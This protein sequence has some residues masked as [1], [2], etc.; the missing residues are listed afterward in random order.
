LVTGAGGFIGREVLRALASDQGAQVIA[1]DTGFKGMVPTPR[2][3]LVAGNIADPVVRSTAI[4]SGIDAVIHLAAVPG[5]AAELD[6]QL[7][8]QVNLDATLDLF[9]AVAQGGNRPRVVFASTIAVFGE[10]LPKAGV[11]DATPLAPRLIY[12]AHKAMIETMLA[13]WHRRGALNGIAVRLPGV[14]ARPKG[15]SGLKSAFMSNLF[16]ALRE[17]QPFVSPV[18]RAATIWLMSVHQVARNLVHALY[19]EDHSL[20]AGR[21]LTL[22]A[23]CVDWSALIAEVAAR[24]GSPVSAVTFEPD[25]A[26]EAAFGAYPPLATVA[27]DRAGFVPDR[28]V[29][30]L[31]SRALEQI[32]RA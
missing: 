25:A 5:G 21:A 14:I 24:T 18:S 16:H 17:G 2:L 23:L 8:R 10:T 29:A 9:D 7:S 20:P 13:T 4:G 31:V 26:L 12:G 28:D 32:A 19:V 11:D 6:P 1:V 15:P 3:Q 27:G 30:T 22:P